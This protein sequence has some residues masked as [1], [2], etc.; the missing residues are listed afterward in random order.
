MK[1]ERKVYVGLAKHAFLDFP[2]SFSKDFLVL[3]ALSFK[4]EVAALLRLEQVSDEN[5]VIVYD[6]FASLTSPLLTLGKSHPVLRANTFVA[7]KLYEVA[8]KS[9]CTV[10]IVTMPGLDSKPRFFSA[11]RP[12][13]SEYTFL[14]RNGENLVVEV[15]D[16]DLNTVLRLSMDPGELLSQVYHKSLDV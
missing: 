11:L 12:Y 1:K 6:G 14:S 15:R 5:T 10:L 9:R 13:A 4:E 3:R 7:A 2:S 8:E 16:K